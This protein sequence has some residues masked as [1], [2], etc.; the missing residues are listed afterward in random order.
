MSQTS[1]NEQIT[2]RRVTGTDGR[3]HMGTD[4]Y[5]HTGTDKHVHMG[6]D[7]CV[8]TGTDRCVCVHMGMDEYHHPFPKIKSNRWI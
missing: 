3:V 6:T 2:D 8:H 5:V 1:N 7:S 4:R